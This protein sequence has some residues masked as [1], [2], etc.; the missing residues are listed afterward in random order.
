[1]VDGD[2]YDILVYILYTIENIMV[3]VICIFNVCIYTCKTIAI[4]EHV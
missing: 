2:S 1:M 3:R 4:V